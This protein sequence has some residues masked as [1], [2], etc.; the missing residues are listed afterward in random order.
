MD[1]VGE[2]C[3]QPRDDDMAALGGFQAVGFVHGGDDRAFTSGN[4]GCHLGDDFGI[5]GEFQP[6]SHHGGRRSTVQTSC[7]PSR[8][9]LP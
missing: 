7:T 4:L 9:G 8:T 6:E 2:A 3:A 5:D 1:R